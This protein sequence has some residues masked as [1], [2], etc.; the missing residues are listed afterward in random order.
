MKTTG[1]GP[2]RPIPWDPSFE[3][4]KHYPHFDAPLRLS[5]IKKIVNDP[6]RVASNA[7]F[8]LIQYEKKWQPF[9][10]PRGEPSETGEPKRPSKKSRLIRYAAR[11]DAYIFARYRRILSPLYELE[12]EKRD[13]AD[14]PIAYRKIQGPTG[15]GKCNIEFARDV[16]DTIKRLGDCY[17]ITLDISKFFES[18]DHERIRK[19][20]ENLLEVRSLPADHKAVYKALTDYRWVDRTEAYRRLG[21]FG[22]KLTEKGEK[23]EGYLTPFAMMPKQ[24]CSPAEFRDKIAGNG[25]Q[26]SIINSNPHQYGIPQGTPIS[27]LIANLYMVD[28]DQ[29]I[30]NLATKSGG[31]AYRYSDDILLI[32]KA[33]SDQAALNIEEDVR[34]TIAQFGSEIKIKEEKSSVHHFFP[35]GENQAF[36]RVTGK[37]ANGLEYLGFRFDGKHVFIRDS[38]LSNLK[39]KMTFAGRIRANRHKRRYSN[40][41]SEE[42]IESFNFDQFF[43]SFMRV[44]DFDTASSVRQ[45]TFWTY[46][47]RAVE[48]FGPRGKPIDRQ[49]KFLKPDGRRQIEGELRS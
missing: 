29:H 15:R 11:R 37:G 34:S 31:R 8:P 18:L 47:R 42:L 25:R 5:E 26:P 6:K 41:T 39:R 44:E 20:W 16:F 9:R 24:L 46:A 7:F 35:D 12:L 30:R 32:V 13:I 4:Q 27:D 3:D 38:T 49:L 10:K 1:A 45:W 43:Q 33:C 21:Y 17:V 40:R 23:I 14:V 28:F 36:R 2:S 22:E 19:L 48:A